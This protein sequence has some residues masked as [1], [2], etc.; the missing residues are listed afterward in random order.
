MSGP[1]IWLTPRYI[2]RMF[3]NGYGNYFD[4]IISTIQE[5]KGQ[6]ADRLLVNNCR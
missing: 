4:Y 5:K 2:D 3:L 1:Y 6:E